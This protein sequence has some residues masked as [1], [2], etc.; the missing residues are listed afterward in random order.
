[1]C[2]NHLQAP[3]GCY[4]HHLLHTPASICKVHQGRVWYFF[5]KVPYP[6]LLYL[7]AFTRQSFSRAPTWMK[8]SQR[9]TPSGRLTL[10]T[11]FELPTPICTLCC[12]A[13]YSSSSKPEGTH[14]RLSV[15]PEMQTHSH[16]FKHTLS[17]F[18]CLS[19]YSPF[20]HSPSDS[21]TL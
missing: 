10:I 13:H 8:R 6:T 11:L 19:L 21:S 9:P 15:S 16:R 2:N 7:T 1:M 4:H 12:A 3:D 14:A 20:I 5:P 18:P 17:A